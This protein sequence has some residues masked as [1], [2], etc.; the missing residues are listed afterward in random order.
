[1][2]VEK[3][4]F[5]DY[6]LPL[7]DNDITLNDIPNLLK[8]RDTFEVESLNKYI[9]ELDGDK[10]K[11]IFNCV[12]KT[13]LSEY[14][15]HMKITTQPIFYIDNSEIVAIAKLKSNKGE[16]RYLTIGD[17][18]NMSKEEYVAPD[19]QITISGYEKHE[20]LGTQYQDYIQ[21]GTYN[22]IDYYFFNCL[23]LTSD[24]KWEN[25]ESE[26]VHS[27]TLDTLNFNIKQDQKFEP[28]GMK[29]FHGQDLYDK[30]TVWL[31]FSDTHKY[32]SIINFDK[33]SGRCLVNRPEL[34]LIFDI[35]VH[36]NW[37][38]LTELQKIK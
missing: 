36:S 17:N 24:A 32:K 35:A 7:F 10:R 19:F 22:Y 30:D 9:S 5:I 18:I 29:D 2:T 3:Q 12:F 23:N 31:Q 1:M 26:V 28:V 27:Y 21:Y 38:N 15:Q 25:T 16:I 37:K 13:L 8:V 14:I 4:R 20:V 34:G 33:K 6:F 11:S